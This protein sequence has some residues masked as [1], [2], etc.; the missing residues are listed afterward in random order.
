[1]G[2]LERRASPC[3]PSLW[4]LGCGMTH[5][6]PKQ[7]WTSE[8]EQ[9]MPR[10]PW[11]TQG[12]PWRLQRRNLGERKASSLVLD[13]GLGSHQHLCEHISRVLGIVFTE[14]GSCKGSNVGRFLWSAAVSR[15]QEPTDPSLLLQLFAQG[16]YS[17]LEPSTP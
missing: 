17:V 9:S 5:G 14:T 3:S 10:L 16:L 6:T 7:L 13:L 12:L 8:V 15:C 11:S 1:M 2:G 4:R